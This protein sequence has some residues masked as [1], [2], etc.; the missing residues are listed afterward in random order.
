MYTGKNFLGLILNVKL[1]GHRH[2]SVQ[3]YSNTKLFSKVIRLVFKSTSSVCLEFFLYI[4]VKSC[5][6]HL[7]LTGL[8][9][10]SLV[11]IVC[12]MVLI[13]VLNFIALI[14][15]KL[16][17]ISWLYW[18]FGFLVLEICLKAFCSFLYCVGC[19]FLICTSSVYLLILCWLY[20]SQ[21]VA[22]VLGFWYFLMKF[23]IL[24]RS[25]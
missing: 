22:C 3:H 21:Y 4:L 24:M 1:L 7:V 8:I 13:V 17:I 19:P 5:F 9:D 11:E 12:K 20:V 25:Y 10:S 23:L 6:W 16:S 18:P 15:M 2:V 14:M